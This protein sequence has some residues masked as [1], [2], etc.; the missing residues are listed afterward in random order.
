MEFEI[1]YREQPYS[2][3]VNDDTLAVGNSEY[4]YEFQQI[5]EQSGYIR[6]GSKTYHIY[7][8]SIKDGELSYTIDGNRFTIPYKDE[9]AILLSKMGFK[10]SKSSNQG[11]IKSPMP[12]KIIAIRKQQGDTVSAGETVV[13]LEAMKMENEL[14]SPVNGTVQ[15]I[16]VSAGQSVEK[17]TLLLEIN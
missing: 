16:V 7:D 9:Q 3:R 2:L 14:K 4:P 11:F 8:I 6:L 10:S 17:N 13:V 12:G 15:N 5:D 1:T